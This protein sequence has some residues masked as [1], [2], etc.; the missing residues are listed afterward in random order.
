[1]QRQWVES[2]YFGCMDIYHEQS[3]YNLPGHVNMA[4]PLLFWS[5]IVI[6]AFFVGSGKGG[7]PMIAMLS[8]PI[9]S[10]VIPPMQGA[11]LLLPVYIISDIAG[12]LIYRK[13]YS[14]I[15]LIILGP[16]A[17]VGIFIGWLMADQTDDNFI[18][19]IIGCVGL[20][21][22]VMQQYSRLFGT[23]AAKPADLPRGLFWGA[24][25]GFTSFVSHAGGPA[26]QLYVLPQKLSKLKFAGTST[27]LFAA[28]N[29]MKL[30]PYI[31][32]GLIEFEAMTKVTI[33][34]PVAIL[35]AIFGYKVTTFIP[36][37]AFFIVVEIALLIISLNL[38]R[39]GMEW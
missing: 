17:A 36:Q 22:L 15:N 24:I 29:L 7:M 8:V 10:L 30:P 27:I 5:I 12:L 39:V 25:S 13:S 1:M 23:N 19:I 9:M 11:A 32:M 33:L 37:Q 14:R 6:S 35:G 26:F 21:F 4:D 16:A 20:A 31:E 3:N 38:I 28:I 2:P 18:R 34:A